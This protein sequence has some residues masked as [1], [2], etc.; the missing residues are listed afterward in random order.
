MTDIRPFTLSIPDARLQHLQ[1]KLALAAFPDELEDAG[2]EHGAPLAD[3]KRLVHHWRTAYDW[4]RHEASINALP[5][6]ETPIDVD[7]FGP[8]D[9]HFVHQ[10]SPNG[11]AIPLLFVHGWPG[12][13]L[14]VAKL[15]PLFSDGEKDGGP[16]FHVVAPS[17]PNFGFSGVVKRKG[18]GM[19]QYAETCHKLMIKLG[20][21]HYVSQGGDWGTFITRTMAMLYPEALKATHIN[22]VA[23]PPPYKNPLALLTL[24]F[25]YLTGTFSED[26]KA[27]FERTQWFQD[28]GFG[29]FKIQSTKPQTVGYA[30]NDSPVA[31]LAWIY[32]KLH[33]WTDNY[34][35]T[36]D[37]ILDWLSVYWWS[38]AGPAA[39]VR[40]YYEALKGDYTTEKTYRTWIPNVKLGLGYFPKELALLP[41]SWAQSLGPITFVSEHKRGGHFA[42]FE[43]PEGIV[44]DM[45]LMFGKGGGAFGV[46]ENKHG[47]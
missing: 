22:M 15:L 5:N 40:I 46:V 3:I 27:G 17:L 6:Y 42:A 45:R 14:E 26:E 4:R 1:D 19:K 47:Y 36:D 41:K 44:G 10:V 34:P 2:W 33:D 16:A 39:S 29:Y 37:E 31:L 32:E 8:I 25:K 24:G 11:N 12:H 21:E 28:H 43:N 20:Y 13:F 9:I 38:R 18:F 23:C 30:L 35:W 7:G